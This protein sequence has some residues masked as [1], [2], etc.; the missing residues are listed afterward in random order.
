MDHQ[1]SVAPFKSKV[2][3]STSKS[4]DASKPVAPAHP[5]SVPV[6][7]SSSSVE[8]AAE[9]KKDWFLAAAAQEETLFAGRASAPPPTTL[10]AQSSSNA[11]DLPSMSDLRVSGD[12]TDGG[13]GGGDAG[14]GGGSEPLRIWAPNSA[15]HSRES[16]AAEATFLAKGDGDSSSPTRSAE[17]DVELISPLGFWR[18]KFETIDARNATRRFSGWEDGAS[19]EEDTPTEGA[20]RST[21]GAR[22]GSG[23]ASSRA[24][25]AGG[26]RPPLRKD[27]CTPVALEDQTDPPAGTAGCVKVVRKLFPSP[28]KPPRRK[29]TPPSGAKKASKSNTSSSSSS[30]SAASGSLEA[31]AEGD[32]EFPSPLGPQAGAGAHPPPFWSTAV[33]PTRDAVASGLVGGGRVV[34]AEDKEGGVGAAGAGLGWRRGEAGLVVPEPM[35]QKPRPVHFQPVAPQRVSRV[36]RDAQQV[37]GGGGGGGGG[38]ADAKRPLAAPRP[39]TTSPTLPNS[40]EH[41]SKAAKELQQAL[42]PGVKIV[43]SYSYHGLGSLALYDSTK[44]G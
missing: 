8:W 24:E 26:G 42:T 35:Q 13:G 32:H 34:R 38:G 7:R 30:S 29:K 17:S 33:E 31:M 14:R 39:A 43:R 25:Q 41:K 3:F 11:G 44:R 9:D 4:L 19:G 36:G 21:G 12:S 5:G 23:G 37:G 10:A 15:T 2:D 22:E 18:E 6:R 1:T 40:G 27:G 16:S 20:P 28:Q